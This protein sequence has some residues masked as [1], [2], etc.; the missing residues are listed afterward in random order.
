M[1]QTTYGDGPTQGATGVES[2]PKIVQGKVPSVCPVR[3]TVS[4][5][6]ERDDLL[7]SVAEANGADRYWFPND[8][9]TW[10]VADSLETLARILDQYTK[11]KIDAK[12]IAQHTAQERRP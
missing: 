12:N 1:S 5:E 6:G 8:Q 7:M 4:F 3:P 2:I 10:I 11:R 9:V